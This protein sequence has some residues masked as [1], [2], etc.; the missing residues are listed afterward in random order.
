MDDVKFCD[1]CRIKLK[2]SELLKAMEI[3]ETYLRNFVFDNDMIYKNFDV[4]RL[5]AS[6]NRLRKLLY[7][8]LTKNI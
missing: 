3:S 1:E 4:S 8:H 7:L 6:F 2:N 5:L